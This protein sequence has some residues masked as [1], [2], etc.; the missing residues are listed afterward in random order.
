MELTFRRIA[1]GIAALTLGLT[2]CNSE[3]Y[4]AYSPGVKYGLRKDPII[5][6][7]AAAKL[8]DER[9]DPERPGVFPLMKMSDMQQPEHPFHAKA[10]DLSDE[11]VRD[12]TLVQADDQ[13]KLEE[14]LVLMFGTPAAPTVNAK[15]I[16]L[17][18][19]LIKELALDDTTLAMGSTRYRVH[20]LHC[21]G[22]PGDGRGP[23]AKWIN[24]HP[25][26][27]RSGTFKF[28][29][30]DQASGKTRVPARGDLVRT[31]RQGIEGTAMPTFSLLKDEELEALVSYVIHLSIRGE[32]EKNTLVYG[33]TLQAGT[34]KPGAPVKDDVKTYAEI[35]AKR[36]LESSSPDV[37][38]KVTKY[39]Y[40]DDDMNAL[41]ASVKRGQAIFTAKPS[42]EISKELEGKLK[43]GILRELE[44]AAQ[45]KK[46]EDAEQ[47]KLNAAIEKKKKEA[48]AKD[49][50]ITKDA[51]EAVYPDDKEVE[52]TKLTDKEKES[53]KLTA[54]EKAAAVEAGKGGADKQA[55][56]RAK[57]MLTGA[58]CVSCH[59]NYGRE[60]LYRFDEWGTLV[61]P[62][63]LA[64]GNLR[65]GKRPVDIYYRV[66]SGINGSGM[67]PFGSTFKGHEYL[68]WDVVNFVQAMPHPAM[69]QSLD[70]KLD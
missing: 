40:R 7:G 6:G 62:N 68:I 33:F 41:K 4:P 3:H 54:Q 22:V 29:S 52:A 11:L 17:P 1:A 34:L 48:L 63:N 42:A 57:S 24:P 10:K 19:S 8:G 53:L 25:R 2:G 44:D 43:D 23:T 28:Q 70:L 31:L 49:P 66:H 39:P 55:V 37:A 46:F 9:Y 38:I 51:L 60:A 65:G 12:P 36:W 18:E 67:T 45:T 32:A 5:K 16:G 21:H 61:R 15:E 20:C 14:A 69:R 30:V 13:K 56:D 35:A 59:K 47:K 50:K 58:N 26:D 27:F 64:I